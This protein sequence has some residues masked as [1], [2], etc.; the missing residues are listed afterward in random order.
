[1]KRIPIKAVIILILLSGIAAIYSYQ[2]ESLL[3]IANIE[4]LAQVE[5]G[6]YIKCYNRIKSDP[7][8]TVR[9][10]GNCDEIP[11]TWKS[12]MDFCLP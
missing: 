7:T 2:K 9:Y 3:F 6:K 12:S 4:I 1:M 11:G 10:C 5:H 8:D